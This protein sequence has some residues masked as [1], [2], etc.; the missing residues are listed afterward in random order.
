MPLIPVLV[1]PKAPVSSAQE[2]FKQY[3]SGK[4]TDAAWLREVPPK[5][6]DPAHVDFGTY[7]VKVLLPKS[8]VLVVLVWV[9][10]P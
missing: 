2:V 4:P 5:Q 10:G 1:V 3:T 8:K 9:P 7:L 6:D